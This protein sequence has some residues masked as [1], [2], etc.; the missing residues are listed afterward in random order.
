MLSLLALP[1]LCIC[2]IYDALFQ[3][4]LKEVKPNIEVRVTL[5]FNVGLLCTPQALS[6]GLWLLE[7][8]LTPTSYQLELYVSLIILVRNTGYSVQSE[9]IR[10]S[11]FLIPTSA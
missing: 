5:L 4:T 3:S 11:L 2:Q 8:V 6:E 9:F 7:T 1:F 10:M